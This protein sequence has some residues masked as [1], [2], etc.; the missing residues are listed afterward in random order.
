MMHMLDLHLWM[1]QEDQ[2]PLPQ[3]NG[4]LH[5][6]LHLCPYLGPTTCRLNTPPAH[7]LRI[8]LVQLD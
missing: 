3:K 5:V 6:H 8:V 2:L 4:P 7:V 1:P